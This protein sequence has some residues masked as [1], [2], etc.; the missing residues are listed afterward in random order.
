LGDKIIRGGTRVRSQG[1]DVRGEGV[2]IHVLDI[3]ERDDKGWFGNGEVEG[4]I[5]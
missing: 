5:K 2:Q 3:A 4:D 1:G